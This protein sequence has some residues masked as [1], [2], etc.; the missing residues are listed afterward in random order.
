MADNLWRYINCDCCAGIKWGGEYPTECDECEGSGIAGWVRP[1]N[2]VFKYP[3]GPAKGQ[4]LGG[5]EKAN[6]PTETQ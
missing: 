6:I 1:S 4:W 2:H 3:G 5:Y